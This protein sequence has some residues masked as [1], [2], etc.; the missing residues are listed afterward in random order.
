MK[1]FREIHLRGP[2]RNTPA[3]GKELKPGTWGVH[4]E[5]MFV[6]CKDCQKL[7]ACPPD[8]ELLELV[9]RLTEEGPIATQEVAD[10]LEEPRGNVG[11]WLRGLK[12]RT[13]LVKRVRGGWVINETE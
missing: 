7:Q 9:R 6:N 8:Q 10:C 4:K 1:L 5:R 11:V 13:G 12:N 3:C 2:N